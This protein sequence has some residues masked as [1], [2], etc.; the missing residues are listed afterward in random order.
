M[1]ILTKSTVACPEAKN[2]GQDR[3]NFELQSYQTLTSNE[4]SERTIGGLK[5]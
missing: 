5:N 2:R 1:E 4:L 3:Q